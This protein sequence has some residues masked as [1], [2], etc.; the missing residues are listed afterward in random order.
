MSC[1]SPP[2]FALLRQMRIHR[3]GFC[4]ELYRG[5]LVSESPVHPVGIVPEE[6]LDELP[7]ERFGIPEEER[8][9]VVREFLLH[10]PVEAFRMRVH[11]G[12]SRIGMIVEEM[13]VPDLFREVLGE[14][15][16][17]VGEDRGEGERKD[18]PDTVEELSG[19][20]GSMGM[21]RPG[22]GETR[23]DIGG[24]ED[25]S[26][27]SFPVFLKG[28]EGDDV[29]R[30]LRFQSFRLSQDLFPFHRLHFSEMG[31]L[32]R[33]ETE[34]AQIANESSD[35]RGFRTGKIPRGTEA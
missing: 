29:P 31:D 17:V 21:G 7:I 24:R 18:Q 2:I 16:P 32:L 6:I 34:S 26:S 22:E 23:V 8:L 30:I 5:K 27:P 33:E 15:A 14:F 20:E 9:P 25:V 12:S 35:G 3:Q 28:I 1:I 10:S 4:Q 19:G 11:L 13:E